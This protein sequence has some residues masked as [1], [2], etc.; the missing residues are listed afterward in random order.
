[1][2]WM[3]HLPM[4][5]AVSV[6]IRIQFHTISQTHQI[7]AIQSP[8]RVESDK[9]QPAQRLRFVEDAFCCLELLTKA[10]YQ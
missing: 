8:E 10:G 9:G 4:F 3:A 2:L 7:Q 5:Q 6:Y 1:M